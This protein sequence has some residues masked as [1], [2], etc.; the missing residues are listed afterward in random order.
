MELV[1]KEGKVKEPTTIV[2]KIKTSKTKT[3]DFK[4]E[5]KST[6]EIFPLARNVIVKTTF[7]VPSAV[8]TKK[9]EILK[10]SP[11]FVEVVAYGCETEELEIGDRVLISYHA[12]VERLSIPRNKLTVENTQ[13]RI[14]EQ[15]KGS[16]FDKLSKRNATIEEFYTIPYYSIVAVDK[17]K[18][19]KTELSLKDAEIGNV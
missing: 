12:S 19:V 9:E 8:I 3:K 11:D 4:R 16:S 13:K 2:G 15:M 10:R 14:M 7:L 18:S 1:N 6:I 5:G 17:S